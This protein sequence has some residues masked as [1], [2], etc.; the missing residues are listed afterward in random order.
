MATAP[1]VADVDARLIL[2]AVV[3]ALVAYGAWLAFRERHVKRRAADAGAWGAPASR[4]GPPASW[5]NGI[6]LSNEEGLGWAPEDRDPVILPWDHVASLRFVGRGRD[7][8]GIRALPTPTVRLEVQDASGAESTFVLSSTA[9]RSLAAAAGRNPHLQSALGTQRGTGGSGPAAPP[10][11]G[12]SLDS[13]LSE[14]SAIRQTRLF[15]VEW[16]LPS[17]AVSTVA[18]WIAWQSDEGRFGDEAWVDPLLTVLF[19][20]AGLLMAF[21]IYPWFASVQRQDRAKGYSGRTLGGYAAVRTILPGG[22]VLSAPFGLAF[23]LQERLSEPSVAVD[24]SVVVFGGALIA[25]FI[26]ALL[27][28]FPAALRRQRW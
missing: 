24:W 5:E 3:A 16:L 9:A 6:L 1:V 13:L 10:S 27:A 19:V 4:I 15:R 22:V 26:A 11:G 8:L 14:I 28:M 18:G 23:R 7:G 25:F 2:P 17:L 12:R 21:G 20:T